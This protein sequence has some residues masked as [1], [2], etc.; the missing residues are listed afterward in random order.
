MKISLKHFSLL[1]VILSLGILCF[2][3]LSQVFL[4]VLNKNLQNQYYILKEKID[5]ESVNPHIIVVELD[6]ESFQKI[7]SIPFGR[8]IYAQALENLSLYNPAVVAF[9]ILFLDPSDQQSDAKLQAA[10]QEFPQGVLGASIH[11]TEKKLSPPIFT[12]PKFGFLSPNIFF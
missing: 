8:E 5:Q 9:D 7:G 6:D 3:I 10:F 2:L 12:S 1:S 11:P 4:E